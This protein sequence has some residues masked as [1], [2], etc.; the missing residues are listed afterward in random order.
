MPVHCAEQAKEN[1]DK[2]SKPEENSNHKA[3]GAKK[4]NSGGKDSLLSCEECHATE[5]QKLLDDQQN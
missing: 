2:L 4:R 1:S 3:I 5:T